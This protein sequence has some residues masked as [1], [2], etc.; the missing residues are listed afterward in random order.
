MR[1]LSIE[2]KKNKINKSA[3]TPTIRRHCRSGGGGPPPAFLRGWY[4]F[5][6]TGEV[7]LNSLSKEDVADLESCQLISRVITLFQVFRYK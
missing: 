5:L 2:N 6:C 1:V 4:N 7:D 3:A